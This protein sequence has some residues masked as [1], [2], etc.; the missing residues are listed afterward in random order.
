VRVELRIDNMNHQIVTRDPELL[1]RWLVEMFGRV[2]WTPATFCQAMVWP[3]WVGDQGAPD[4]IGDT[5]VIGRLTPVSSPQDFVNMLQQQ[6]DD[7]KEIT[8]GRPAAP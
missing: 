7:M 6:I 1:G 5:R 4:W 8:D 2:N 3:D